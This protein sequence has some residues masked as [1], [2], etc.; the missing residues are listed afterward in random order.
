MERGGALVLSAKV[1]TTRS[2]ENKTPKRKQT[3]THLLILCATRLHSSANPPLA[4]SLSCVTA[5]GRRA[6]SDSVFPVAVCA[7]KLCEHPRFDSY[8][9]A[10]SG[11]PCS[12]TRGWG[13]G[14]DGDA[15]C[16]CVCVCE[17]VPVAA[18]Q[19][20]RLCFDLL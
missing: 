10:M 8:A 17:R 20:V 9:R 15:V 1:D 4:A 5:N 7:T 3:K 13:G 12:G 14:E 11:E 16:V 18:C 19:C 6:P 2:Q